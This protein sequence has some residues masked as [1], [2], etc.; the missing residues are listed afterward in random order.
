M[1]SPRK[2]EVN[3]PGAIKGIT[4]VIL[5]LPERKSLGEFCQLFKEKL[6][7]YTSSR[8]Q[9]GVGGNTYQFIL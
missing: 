7:P 8:K 6:I 2:R 3:S 5:N 9:K 4:L 1:D